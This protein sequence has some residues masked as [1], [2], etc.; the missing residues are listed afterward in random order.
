MAENNDKSAF[1]DFDIRYCTP[2]T[3]AY[4]HFPYFFRGDKPGDCSLFSGK[5]ERY[6]LSLGGARI[7]HYFV[8]APGSEAGSPSECCDKHTP[9]QQKRAD[10]HPNEND[11]GE[12]KI[13]SQTACKS[14]RPCPQTEKKCN[15]CRK[16]KFCGKKCDSEQKPE[17]GGRH[18]KFLFK[19]DGCVPPMPLWKSLQ[20][21][22][23]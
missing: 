10:C 23:G 12:R 19:N 18:D 20:A 2:E 7:S 1:R 22:A 13:G 9:Q 14:R 8:F 21:A 11:Q 4:S 6:C 16:K 3:S 5:H 17:R 15:E